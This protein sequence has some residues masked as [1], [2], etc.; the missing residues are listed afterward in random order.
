MLQKRMSVSFKIDS[1]L[2]NAGILG[3][4]GETGKLL[5][6]EILHNNIFKSLTLIGRRVVEYQD[7]V[8]NNAVRY[9]F[10]AFLKTIF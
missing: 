5:A 3:Y 2:L 1:K 6:F 7:S 8:Y 9:I 4:T 10:E